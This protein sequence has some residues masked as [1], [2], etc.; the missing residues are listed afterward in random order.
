MVV[1]GL[2]SNKKSVF[3]INGV[4]SLTVRAYNA[5]L[6]LTTKEVFEIV[7]ALHLK[8]KIR[9]SLLSFVKKII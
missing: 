9:A 4:S 5:Y 8:M 3:S 2:V 7:E 6:P 1:Y